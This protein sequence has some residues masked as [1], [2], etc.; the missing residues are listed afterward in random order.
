MKIGKALDGLLSEALGRLD[1]N[2]VCPLPGSWINHV[3]RGER[4][5]GGHGKA[6]LFGGHRNVTLQK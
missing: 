5:W 1:V 6:Q 4:Q 3:W 2:T